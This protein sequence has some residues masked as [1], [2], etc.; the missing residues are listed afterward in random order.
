MNN[1]YILWFLYLKTLHSTAYKI[2]TKKLRP[3][4]SHFYQRG[5]SGMLCAI[6][7]CCTLQRWDTPRY[8][9]STILHSQYNIN[10]I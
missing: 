1:L 2:A 5:M 3:Q 8:N 6:H 10:A 9:I 4:V 7:S